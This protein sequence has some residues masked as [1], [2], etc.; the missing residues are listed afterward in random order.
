MARVMLSRLILMDKDISAYLVHSDLAIYLSP[1]IPEPIGKRYR[2]QRTFFAK[3]RRVI[4][5]PLPPSD[6]EGN[7]L[8]A[9]SMS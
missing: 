3:A 6:F 5:A 1:E 8:E 2:M 4:L 9:G 7:Y